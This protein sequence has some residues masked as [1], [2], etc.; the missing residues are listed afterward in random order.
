MAERSVAV[1]L[2]P[3]CCFSVFVICTQTIWGIK[4]NAWLTVNTDFWSRVRR[5]ANA[6]REWRSH[7]RRSSANHITTDQKSL[8]TVNNVL[9]YFL[10]AIFCS[11]HTIPP[12]KHNHR[13]LISPWE[14]FSDLELWRHHGSVTSSEREVL[15]FNV[16]LG[17]TC[18]NDAYGA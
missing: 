11:E 18:G 6:F 9:F 1:E 4:N 17:P 14:V 3:W 15:H 5:Y 16:I 2:D 8:F 10:Q 12:K 7:E 13:S